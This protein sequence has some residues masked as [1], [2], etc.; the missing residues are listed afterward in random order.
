MRKMGAIVTADACQN[1]KWVGMA[2]GVEV[3]LGLDSVHAVHLSCCTQEGSLSCQ[4]IAKHAR[5]QFAN[6]IED[7][8]WD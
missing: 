6:T 7:P 1:S 3:N 2:T 5:P 4:A 8:Q